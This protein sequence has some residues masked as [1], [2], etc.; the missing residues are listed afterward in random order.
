MD[1]IL[2]LLLD[3]LESGEALDDSFLDQVIAFLEQ[4]ETPVSE[5]AKLLWTL[6]GGNPEAFV[7]YIQEFKDPAL[8]NLISNPNLLESTIQELQRNNPIERNGIED[9]IPQADLQ[10]SNIYGFQFNPKNKKLRVRFQEGAVYEYDGVPDIIFNLFARGQAAA[11]TNGKNNFGRW[12]KG[13]SPSLGASLNQYI[14][15][16]GYKYRRLR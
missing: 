12:W 15:K 10:S 9:G 16:G 4:G 13:K 3:V 6:A 5:N 7:S 14:K 11:K 8:D 1:E 2:D